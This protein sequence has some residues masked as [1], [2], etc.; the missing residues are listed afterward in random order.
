MARH[1][2][3]IAIWTNEEELLEIRSYLAEAS[4]SD[5][6]LATLGKLAVA[7]QNELDHLK[8][9]E[10]PQD[11]PARVDPDYPPDA[12]LFEAMAVEA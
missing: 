9:C 4:E 6:R 5:P 7:V 10:L 3:R 11:H 12:Y 1:R 8:Y 2:T